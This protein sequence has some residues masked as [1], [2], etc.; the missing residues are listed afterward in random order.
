MYPLIESHRADLKALAERYGV[1]QV[2][3]FL[4]GFA[5]DA[6]TPCWAGMWKSSPSRP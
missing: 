6:Q 5:A 2:R 1:T 3:V 4:G